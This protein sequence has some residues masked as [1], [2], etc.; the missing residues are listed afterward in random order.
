MNQLDG[1]TLK[2][3]FTLVHTHDLSQTHFDQ[4]PAWANYSEPDD[5]EEIANWGIERAAILQQLERIHYS[6]EFLFPVLHHEPLPKFRFLYLKAMIIA[7]DGSRLVGYI[8]G[9]AP[10]CLTVFHG[11]SQFTFNSNLR[12]LAA[13]EL[14][15]LRRI[16]QL[17]L[18]PF[19]PLHYSTTFRRDDGE[20]IE[21]QLDCNRFPNRALR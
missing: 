18:T 19:F 20:K 7:A 21:G 4:Y 12:D 6:D 11:D 14:A 9:Q 8:V 5:I 16:S 2:A 1:A 17:S 3:M 15:R 10:H 13:E